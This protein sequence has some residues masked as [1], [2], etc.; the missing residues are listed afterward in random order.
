MIV[1]LTSSEWRRVLQWSSNTFKHLSIRIDSNE[2]EESEHEESINVQ[3]ESLSFPRLQ[4]LQLWV[5]VENEFPNWFK[6]PS[7]LVLLVDGL[8]LGASVGMPSISELWIEDLTEWKEI[9]N[10]CPILKVLRFSK[11]RLYPQSQSD[12]LSL[13]KARS[14]NVRTGLKVE[15]IEMEMLQTL[16]IPFK[17]V[18]FNLLQEYRTLVGEV[19]DLHSDSVSDQ[20]EVVIE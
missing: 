4:V 2:E 13:L 3:L 5:N 6:V 1:G 11:S 20:I 8:G 9:S 16:V 18:P 15:G 19:L 17:G 14:E 10:S 7:S 12:L